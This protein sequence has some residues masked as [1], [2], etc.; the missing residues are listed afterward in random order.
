MNNEHAQQ[1]KK[2]KEVK[3]FCGIVTASCSAALLVPGGSS[4]IDAGIDYAGVVELGD[5]ETETLR[6]SC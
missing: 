3:R 4:D 2:R 6:H 5:A 1:Q